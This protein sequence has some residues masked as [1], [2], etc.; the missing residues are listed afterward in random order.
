MAFAQ[1]AEDHAGML[2]RYTILRCSLLAML[3]PVSF[4]VPW[5]LKKVTEPGG[6]FAPPE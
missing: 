5:Y 1:A 6:K 4:A 3:L 2:T